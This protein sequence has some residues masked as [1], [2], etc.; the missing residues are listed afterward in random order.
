MNYLCLQKSMASV[1]IPTELLADYGLRDPD[2]G[3]PI[4]TTW[5]QAYNGGKLGLPRES[6]NFKNDALPN[7]AKLVIVKA[8]LEL[9][10]MRGEPISEFHAAY[11]LGVGAGLAVPLNT[12]L[13]VKYAKAI[14]KGFGIFKGDELE[15][16][17]TAPTG[18]YVE[19]KL[20]WS[21]DYMIANQASITVTEIK[22]WMRIRNIVPTSTTNKAALKTE[23][24]NFY[25]I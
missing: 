2:T 8:D 20:C 16:T 23:I 13:S 10:P 15:G 25:G 4:A 5:A 3:L 19:S 11:A 14:T 7:Q 6:I 9:I 21:Y 24:D 22:N 17:G 12:L 18:H 1:N